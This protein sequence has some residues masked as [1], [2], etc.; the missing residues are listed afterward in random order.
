[1]WYTLS[2]DTV[3]L[4]SSDTDFYGGGALPNGHL[5]RRVSISIVQVGGSQVAI[6]FTKRQEDCLEGGYEPRVCIKGYDHVFSSDI[7]WRRPNLHNSNA[8]E[9]YGK[10]SCLRRYP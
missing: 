2:V 3:F 6:F 8:L 5:K 7:L 4:D 10:N 9:I 1:M